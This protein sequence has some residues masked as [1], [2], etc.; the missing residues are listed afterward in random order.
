V[1]TLP[2]GLARDGGDPAQEVFWH[3]WE[4][5]ERPF[6]AVERPWERADLVID[7]APELP[8]DPATELV[9]AAHPA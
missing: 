1:E 6:L 3:E 9:V 7:G 2:R 4:A 5:E 8:P